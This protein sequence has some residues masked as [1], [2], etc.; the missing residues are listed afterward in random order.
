M[1]TGGREAESLLAFGT[2]LSARSRVPVTRGLQGLLN[3][4]Q[5]DLCILTSLKPASQ[6]GH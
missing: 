2:K 5:E 6:P 4:L 1:A 3:D